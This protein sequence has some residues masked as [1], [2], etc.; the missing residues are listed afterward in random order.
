MKVKTKLKS[1]EK[2]DVRKLAQLLEQTLESFGITSRVVEVNNLKDSIQ[3]CLEVVL[4]TNIKKIEKIDSTI[5]M[6]LASPTGKV[7]IE[8]P[9]PGRSLIGVTVPL[10]KSEEVGERLGK[11]SYKIIEK[12][13]EV[14]KVIDH[15]WWRNIKIV[16]GNI[17]ALLAEGL[18]KLAEWIWKL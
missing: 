2:P 16:L 8:A 1:E 5:A 4:G 9:I 12:Q 10:G 3:F 11:V 7:Q 18:G 13:V 15:T 14:E 17:C 6:A